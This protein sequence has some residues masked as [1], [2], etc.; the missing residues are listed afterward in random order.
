MIFVQ[1]LLTPDCVA[2]LIVLCQN[3]S[4]KPTSYD[5]ISYSLLPHEQS[6]DAHSSSYTRTGNTQLLS[7]SLQLRQQ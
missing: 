5:R 6:R 2:M 7:L 3:Y 4:N 1:W